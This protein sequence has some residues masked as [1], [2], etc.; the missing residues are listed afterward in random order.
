M[1]LGSDIDGDDAGGEIG[2]SVSLSDDGTIMAIGGNASSTPVKVYEL[3]NEVWVQKG[4]N[5]DEEDS[6]D[7]AGFSVSLNGD[8]TVLAIG[9]YLNDGA[10]SNAGHVRIYEWSGSAW[11]QKVL[12]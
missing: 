1:Q 9:A 6:G 2:Q 4:S 10:G 11:V 8:G 5:I 7:F 12:I 3:S